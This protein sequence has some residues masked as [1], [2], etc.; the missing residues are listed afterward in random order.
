MSVIIT[1]SNQNTGGDKARKVRPQRRLRPSGKRKGKKRGKYCHAEYRIRSRPTPK[2]PDT[3]RR[4]PLIQDLFLSHVFVAW[5]S[6]MQQ[7]FEI[8]TLLSAV[9]LNFTHVNLNLVLDFCIKIANDFTGIFYATY[10]FK[11]W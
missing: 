5:I 10:I 7:R 9:S 2:V 6:D 3:V 4:T 1:A 11:R 8:R